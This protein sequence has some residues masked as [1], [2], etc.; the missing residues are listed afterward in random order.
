MRA[1]DN[2]FP[3]L[4]STYPCHP[5]SR[6]RSP[7]VLALTRRV[8]Q[9]TV[10]VNTR[11]HFCRRFPVDGADQSRDFPK[12]RHPVTKPRG[13]N[14]LCAL[15]ISMSGNT[16][17]HLSAASDDLRKYKLQF[18]RNRWASSR[19]KSASGVFPCSRYFPTHRCRPCPSQ[20]SGTP[21][22]CFTLRS[23]RPSAP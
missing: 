15:S 1:P 19:Q 10:L 3:Y 16:A 17:T 13:Q 18:C 14:R 7:R 11:L 21:R 9:I 20:A 4:S 22:S 12:A 6:L 8:F 5:Q 2:R 23:P